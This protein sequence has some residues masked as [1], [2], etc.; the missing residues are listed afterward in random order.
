MT[1]HKGGKP[2]W[3]EADIQDVVAFIE[4]LNDSDSKAVGK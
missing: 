1:N 4:T 3:S 2:V